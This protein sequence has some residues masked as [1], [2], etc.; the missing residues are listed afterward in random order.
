MIPILYLLWVLDKFN[1]LLSIPIF[2]LTFFV[3]VIV[4]GLVLKS[5]IKGKILILLVGL[6]EIIVDSY[7]II[8]I[9]SNQ[10]INNDNELFAFVALGILI[11]VSY[12]IVYPTW[13]SIKKHY[14]N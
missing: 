7:I 10:S 14:S 11:Y 2:I 3:V 5:K 13:K 8:K 1:G 6:A 9:F 4:F 12:N